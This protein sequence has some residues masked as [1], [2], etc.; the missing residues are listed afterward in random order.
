MLFPVSYGEK[1]IILSASFPISSDQTKNPSSSSSSCSVSLLSMPSTA[2]GRALKR[3]R[4]RKALAAFK[5]TVCM[6][7]H[8]GSRIAPPEFKS[9]V[10]GLAN[11]MGGSSN[12]NSNNNNNSKKKK[13]LRVGME[14]VPLA[15]SRGR[16]QKMRKKKMMTAMGLSQQGKKSEG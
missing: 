16:P 8:T 6:K 1:Q 9:E 7:T 11:K 12:N 13:L 2:F 10:L 5:R 15:I 14:Q 3:S 4:G